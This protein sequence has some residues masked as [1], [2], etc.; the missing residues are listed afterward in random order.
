MSEHNSNADQLIR[1]TLDSITR[2]QRRARIWKYI[3]RGLFLA[4]LLLVTALFFSEPGESVGKKPEKFVV[5][6]DINGIISPETPTA[7][8]DAVTKSLRNAF[9]DKGTEAIILRINSPGGSPVQSAYIYDEINRL[10]DKYPDTPVYAVIAD[11]GASGAYYIAAAADSIYANES[12][13]VG[14]IGVTASGFGA[15]DLLDKIGLERRTYTAGKHKNFLDPFKPERADERAK[16]E[17]VL[18]GTHEQF[19]N[20]VLEGRGARIQKNHPDIFSGMIW[21]GRQALELGLIDGLG[22]AGFVARE[23]VGNEKML[24]FTVDE[25]VLQKLTRELGMAIGK[26][27]GTTL[28]L[29]EQLRLE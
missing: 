22:S 16:W 17:T 21:N 19:I 18:A 13:L 24:D 20:S 5:H 6:I 28:G 10:R 9:K 4:Y 11:L 12:S 25:S 2:E 15:V 23:V 3:F 14:S 26:G 27:L 1:D 8:A 29:S 7:N